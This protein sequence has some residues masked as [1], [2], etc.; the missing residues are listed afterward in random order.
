[1]KVERMEEVVAMCATPLA[2]SDGTGSKSDHK[3]I[4]NSEVGRTSLFTKPSCELA[5]K[6]VGMAP[7]KAK[8]RRRV[9]SG[10]ASASDKS[11]KIGGPTLHE[12]EKCTNVLH[13]NLNDV[14]GMMQLNPPGFSLAPCSL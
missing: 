3:N 4:T 14:V 12:E 11:H 9:S 7:K 6:L 2:Y 13:Y 8:S 1:M 5:G 10:E